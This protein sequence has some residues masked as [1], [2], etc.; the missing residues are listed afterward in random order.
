MALTPRVSAWSERGRREEFRGG[1]IHV[2]GRGGREPAPASPARVPLELLRLV[3]AVGCGRRTTRPSPPTSS[4]SGSPRSRATTTTRLLW[5]ADMVEELV[6]RRRRTPSVFLVAHDM[7][8]SV[9]TELLARDIEG[10]LRDGSKAGSCSSTAL[11]VPRARRA[12]PWRSD[13]PQPVGPLF[14]AALQRAVLPPP[15]RLD[16]SAGASADRRGGRGPVGLICAAAGA[17]STTR[18][19]PTWR[20]A[21]GT[22]S[23]GTGRSA[24]GRG[25]STWPGECST[26]SPRAGA[27][28]G[29]GAQPPG[30]AHRASTI[31]ATTH[32]SR[33]RPGSTTFSKSS[34]GRPE[35]APRPRGGS[36]L[37][38]RASPGPFGHSFGVGSGSIFL[39]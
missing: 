26:R 17:P 36:A 8:T 39:R 29:S 31:S 6:R 37:Y 16:L 12:R 11:M 22:P 18:R 9:T 27:G 34:P 21:S 14:P 15:V 24:T 32:R 10:R 1:R 2:F 5:Q 23:A 35:R 4:A 38:L 3:V 33:P 19:S 30:A 13:P 25:R 7:G 20:S 28:R